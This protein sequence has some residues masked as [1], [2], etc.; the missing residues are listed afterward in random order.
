MWP[1]AHHHQAMNECTSHVQFAR[2][3][4]YGLPSRIKRLLIYAYQQSCEKPLVHNT[5]KVWNCRFRLLRTHTTFMQL[6][7]HLVL[8]KSSRNT[9]QLVSSKTFE[10]AGSITFGDTQAIGVVSWSNL[11][12][13]SH[14]DDEIF[15][16]A[17]LLRT[18]LRPN[19]MPMIS[20]RYAKETYLSLM[21]D[22][23]STRIGYLST[24]RVCEWERDETRKTRICDVS[25][26]SQ[27]QREKDGLRQEKYAE[28]TSCCWFEKGALITYVHLDASWY[29]TCYSKRQQA[30]DMQLP[31]CYSTATSTCIWFF[32]HKGVRQS[33]LHAWRAGQKLWQSELHY[34]GA[35]T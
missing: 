18:F 35:E 29:T 5:A 2:R 4:V 27:W 13:H 30:A 32:N 8:T 33:S 20:K 3:C 22:D 15:F 10:I 9:S 21:R 28:E 19:D 31:L 34:S 11:L 17:Y 7:M 12:Q 24:R 25:Y 14:C 23:K 16:D 6:Q 1:K 26:S